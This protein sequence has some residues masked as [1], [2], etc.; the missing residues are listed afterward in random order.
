[1]GVVTIIDNVTYDL[2]NIWDMLSGVGTVGAVMVSLVLASRDSKPKMN[3]QLSIGK[4]MRRFYQIILTKENLSTFTI[5]SVGYYH[6]FRKK[7]IQLN[8]EDYF[9]VLNTENK[10]VG[11][12]LPYEFSS[13]NIVKIVVEEEIMTSI[14]NKK[15]RFYVT[16]INGKKYKTNKVLIQDLRR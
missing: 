14:L 16:D 13:N 4:K 15:V 2:G 6:Y 10:T 3:A 9:R 11:R 12:G 8:G 7:T 1:M 5:I